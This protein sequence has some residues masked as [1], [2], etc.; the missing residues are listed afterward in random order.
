MVGVQVYE[1]FEENKKV[2]L[3]SN[4]NNCQLGVFLKPWR[5]CSVAYLGATNRNP[6]LSFSIND[7]SQYSL[8]PTKVTA[9]ATIIIANE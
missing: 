2:A 6:G 7:Y 1:K 3:W 8:C 9:G 4:N 5:D